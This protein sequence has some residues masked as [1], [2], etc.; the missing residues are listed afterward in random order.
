MEKSPA[1]VKRTYKETLDNA[2]DQYDGDEER[3]HRTAW[4]SVK[5][6]AFKKGDRWELKKADK[7]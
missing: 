7:S 3:A 5:N 1:K 2:L 6:I 4:A